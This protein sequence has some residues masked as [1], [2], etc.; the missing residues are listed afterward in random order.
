MSNSANAEEHRT[1]IALFRYTL[2]LPLLREP[3]A[4]ARQQ[5][6]RNLA[7]VVYDL[8]HSD[9]RQVSI[10]TLRRWEARYRKGGFEALKPQPRADRGQPRAVSPETLDRAEALKREQPFR[11]ARSIATIL[12]LDNTQ[13]IPEAKLAPRTLRRQLAQRG[14]TTAQLLTEQR[15]KPYRR[16]ERS[17]FGD[18]WQG[19]AMHGPYLPDPAQ[20]DQPR[21]VF[22]FAF[23]DD[24]TRLVPHVQFYWNEQ[25]PRLE[26]CFKRAV[27]RYGLPL[28][29]YVDRG[30]VY[31]SK[32]FDTICATL[33]V[34]RILGTPYSPEGRGKI[35]RFFHFVQT[36]FLPELNRSEVTSLPQLNE[37]LLAWLEVVYHRQ[38]NPEIGQS[39]LERFRQ[40]SQ[41]T[42][43]P[44]DPATLRQAFLH[45]D[46][47]QVTKTATV[48]FQGN[49]YRVPDYLRGQTVE[50]RYDPFDLSQLELWFRDTFLQRIQPDHL[51]NPSHPDVEPDPR[52]AAP[53]AETGLDY[54]ALLRCEHQRLIQAQLEGIH[55]SQLTDRAQAP[56]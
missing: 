38:L 13:P 10:A 44:V 24:H 11:S 22:L 53:P 49:R 43:R 54:L 12:S 7:M 26:D 25:L 4:R 19:D 21:Q 39:P 55:F 28:A 36:D 35:E 20:P 9:R 30:K 48:S 16:F 5:M 33:G 52:P 1:E 34:Q 17:A 51:V 47:R 50:L 29:V 23:L 46:Q 32:Q 6:R 40:Q 56:G 31:T 37:S 41:L 18:L 27:L 8:P 2:I 14:A 45:R 15:P 42:T 3:S